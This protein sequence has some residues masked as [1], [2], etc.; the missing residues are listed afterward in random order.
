MSVRA[1][2]EPL[3]LIPPAG[4]SAPARWKPI[5]PPDGFKPDLKRG[6]AWCPYCGR[7]EEFAWDAGA[8]YAKCPGCGISAEDFYTKTANR[9]WDEGRMDEFVDAVRN[10][11][12]AMAGTPPAAEGEGRAP[13]E[14]APLEAGEEG[15][16]LPPPWKEVRCPECGCLVRRAYPPA[17]LNCLRC[18]SQV[19]LAEGGG[20][21][22]EPPRGAARCRRCGRL[23]AEDPR[24]GAAYY[25]PACGM[26]SAA[27][28]DRKGEKEAEAANAAPFRRARKGPLP[29][30]VLGRVRKLV[31]RECVNYQAS[32][33]FGAK[34]YCDLEPQPEGACVFFAAA[35]GTK[36]CCRWFEEAVLPLEPAVEEAYWRE[37][38]GPDVGRGETPAAGSEAAAREAKTAARRAAKEARKVLEEARK[39]REKACLM[40]GKAFTP[41]RG[42]EKSKYCSESCR[43]DAEKEQTRKWRERKAK[44]SQV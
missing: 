41:E 3:P 34:R 24:P 36:H 2:R 37:Y 9:L 23:L 13:E 6:L 22:W 30:P 7:A 12:R 4:E 42:R 35:G 14:E 16:A 29:G 20:L 32:G 27:P 5:S 19:S 40:C 39:K 31:G 11:G 38:G 8:W 26:W 21:D 25:C 18:G 43:R 44:G 15:V 28:G 1:A 17:E 33:P 10:S